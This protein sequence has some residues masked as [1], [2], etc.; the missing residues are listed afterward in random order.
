MFKTMADGSFTAALVALCRQ[1]LSG[2]RATIVGAEERLKALLQPNSP[3]IQLKV[4]SL[5]RIILLPSK[6][7]SNPGAITDDDLKV[8]SP[9]VQLWATIC[10]KNFVRNH[11]DTSEAHGGVGDQFR[12]LVRCLLLVVALNAECLGLEKAVL[13]QLE[14]TLQ[15]LA[16]SDFPHHMEFALLFMNYCHLSD[17]SPESVASAFSHR[18]QKAASSRAP[19]NMGINVSVENSQSLTRSLE[20]AKSTVHL[21]YGDGL[22]RLVSTYASLRQSLLGYGNI[23]ASGDLANLGRSYGDFYNNFIRAMDSMCETLKNV[24]LNDL[25]LGKFLQAAAILFPKE[26]ISNHVVNSANGTVEVQREPGDPLVCFDDRKLYKD[27]NLWNVPGAS[28]PEPGAQAQSVS[29]VLRPDVLLNENSVDLLYFRRKVQALNLFKKLMNKY[30][31]SIYGDGTLSELKIVLVLTENMLLY[32]FKSCFSKLREYMPILSQAASSQCVARLVLD[33]LEAVT[34]ITKV[35]TYIHA[36]DLPECCE[37]NANIYLGGLMELLRFSNP[38]VQ[39]MD[40]SEI[41]LKLKVAICKLMRYYAERYQEVF[42]PFVFACIEEVVTICK[43]LSDQGEDDRL[44]SAILDFLTAAAATHWGPHGSLMSPFVNAE[45]VADMIRTIVL[46]N[47]GFRE[48]DL[49]LIDDSPVEFVQRELDTGSGYSRRFSAINLLKKLVATYGE[50]VQKILNQFASNVSSSNDYKLKELYLQ[51]IIC[52]NF[53]SNAGFNVPGY[54]SDHVKGDLVRESQALQNKQENVLIAMALLKFVFTFKKQIS[55][56]ELASMVGPIV[57][58]LGHQNHAVRYLAAE[59]LSRILPLVR[60]RKSQVKQ[61][62]LQGLECLLKS[63]RAEEP[64]EFYVRCVMRI[65]LFLRQDVRESG[66]MMLDIIVQLIKSASDN[67]VN[68][69]FNHYLFECLSI[70][71]RIHLEAGSMQAVS[72]IEDTLIPTIAI[73]I[74]QELHPFVPYSLQILYVLLRATK[75]SSDTYVQLFNHLTCIDSWRAS[76]ANAQG[77]AKLLVCYFE[78]YTMFEKEVSAKIESVLSIFHF[79]LTHRK[80]SLVAL[81]LFNGI[82]RYLPVSFYGKFLSS[83]VT[84]FLTFIHNMKTSD[85]IPKV[86]TS[87]SLLALTLHMQQHA[88]GLVATMESIQAGITKNFLQVVFVPNAR[89]VLAL[90]AKRVLVLGT[91]V[92]M[93]SPVVQGSVETFSMLADFLV[94]LIQGQSLRIAP[95]SMDN[96]DFDKLM[97]DMDFDVTYVKLRSVDSGDSRSGSRLLDPSCNVEQLLKTTLQPASGALR[98]LPAGPSAQ[99]LLSLLN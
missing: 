42:H 31:T 14:E 96:D 59:T 64:S 27:S 89:K 88:V 49:Y 62:L 57:A 8:L 2:D 67:P 81:E 10:L 90:E 24:T 47:I 29:I 82:V 97:Q 34:H 36:V 30:K 68:P 25:E 37:D 60:E 66:F 9:E 19:G 73:I 40:H 22:M 61:V 77:A 6:L 21:A 99:V 18:I 94:D 52:S 45:F 91:A 5:I 72:H 26:P 78:R 69:V 92:L 63:M 84:V 4:A 23:I 1:T 33:L 20:E 13:L 53:K 15:M 44:C 93:T 85:I 79:C 80:L 70:L 48:C 16:D 58:F 41:V 17:V 75:R 32:V 54:F 95:P 65:F 39:Q 38:V 50:M 98:Q 43:G 51:L 35:L 86:V 71:L 55:D 74:Q 87:M 83:I 46:P 3:D 28:L 7:V 11:F 12:R 76:T 56:Q